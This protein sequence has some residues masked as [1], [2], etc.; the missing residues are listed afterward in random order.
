M[1]IS[2]VIPA[3]NEEKRLLPTLQKVF[4]YLN[5]NFKSFE[6]LVVDDGSKDGTA[7]I[8]Q[9][10]AKVQ[11][12][13]KLLQYPPPAAN[14]GKG[15]AVRFGVLNATADLILFYDA[16]GATPIEELERLIPVIK[17]DGADVAIGSRAKKSE[18]TVVEKKQYRHIIGSTFNFLVQTFFLK[19]IE[20]SQCGF[21][22]FKNSVAKELFAL[23][24]IDGFSF[25][26]EILYLAGK[27][28]YKVIEI[29]VN[30]VD[31]EG[32]KVNVFVDSPKM[33]WQMILIKIRDIFGAYKG[34]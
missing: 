12:S 11:S 19:G 34:H 4:A 2:V 20:D 27:Q 32:S 10:Y 13:T 1:E 16:D 21:K 3:Y 15:G 22:L 14:R 17:Q 8:V 26:V 33:L 29:P 24:K 30:W 25:D 31:Q 9:D 5:N 28:G 6:I 7:R 18:D 23:G